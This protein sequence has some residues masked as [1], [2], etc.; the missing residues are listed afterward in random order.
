MTAKSKGENFRRSILA[1]IVLIIYV[2]VFLLYSVYQ[3][4]ACPF[5]TAEGIFGIAG[6]EFD[7]E[8]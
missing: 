6:R 8:F 5:G 7:K 3:C 2:L 4:N 1:H